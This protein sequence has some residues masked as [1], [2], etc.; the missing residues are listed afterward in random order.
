MEEGDEEEVDG[1]ANKRTP[2]VI[3]NTCVQFVSSK[4]VDQ[5]EE[6]PK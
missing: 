4:D 6:D 1:G 2:P 5:E 3:D